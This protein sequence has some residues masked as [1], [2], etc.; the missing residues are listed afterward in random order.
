M[1]RSELARKIDHATAILATL[2]ARRENYF[3]LPNQADPI[4]IDRICSCSYK[5][6]VMK[7]YIAKLKRKLYSR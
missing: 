2:I 1:T 7:S 6:G 5:I 3:A 4:V